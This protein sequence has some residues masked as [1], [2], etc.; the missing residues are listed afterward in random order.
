MPV[1]PAP[2]EQLKVMDAAGQ[3]NAIE[4]PI[5]QLVADTLQ[6]K[7]LP[8][9]AEVQAEFSR[10]LPDEYRPLIDQQSVFVMSRTPYADDLKYFY[11]P[12]EKKY[13][14]ELEARL[15]PHVQGKTFIDLGCGHTDYARAFCKHYG[16]ARYLGVDRQMKWRT[17]YFFEER[18]I[19]TESII[20][21]QVWGYHDETLPCLFFHGDMLEF[22]TRMQQ[23]EN[24]VVLL[25]GIQQDD[26]RA[27][28]DEYCRKLWQEIARVT[29]TGDLLM[30]GAAWTSRLT[31]YEDLQDKHGFWIPQDVHEK[32]P[33]GMGYILWAKESS[34]H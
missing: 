1:K 3:P 7:P 2:Y 13:D 29:G 34:A 17:R 24:N 33:M 6:R 25:S 16:L 10:L 26:H 18:E 23:Q 4:L 8:T 22:L 12:K 30:V 19:K 27:L 31:G 14:L 15:R 11:D 9:A 20:P 5:R 32:M 21:D 28:A